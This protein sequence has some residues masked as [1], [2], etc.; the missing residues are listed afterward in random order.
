MTYR[1]LDLFSGIG[2]FSLGLERTNGFQTVAFCE[3]DP[4]C[5]RVLKKHWPEVP[6]YDDVRELTAERLAT[7][8]IYVDVICGGFPCTDISNAGNREGIN[9]EQSKLWSEIARLSGEL[10]PRY[11]IVENASALLSRGLDRVLGDLAALRYDAEWHCIPA[12]N[13]GAPHRRDRFWIVGYPSSQRWCHGLS[14]EDVANPNGSGYKGKRS[15]QSKGWG[16]FA[17]D[18]LA[19]NWE[20]ASEPDVCRMANGLPD[21]SHRIRVLGNAVVPQIPELIGKAILA[22]EA[23][24]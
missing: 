4:F 22:A 20:W 23:D 19:R 3:I 14:A 5:R 15:S 24:S 6:C 10:R 7:D 17:A 9:G 8:G 1:V 18:S 21:W 16:E 13:V 12:S 11:I 2:G